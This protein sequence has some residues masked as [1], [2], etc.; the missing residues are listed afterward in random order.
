MLR[1]DPLE[2]GS[3]GAAHHGRQHR[4]AV[5][6]AL[7]PTHHDLAAVEVDVL[8]AQLQALEQA[9]AGAVEERRHQPSRAGEPR[10]HGRHL[11]AAEH[12]GDV[13]R[14]PRANQTVEPRQLHAEHVPVEEQQRTE[15][16]VLGRRAH[17]AILGQVREEAGHLL[18]SERR[19]V[20]LVVKQNVPPDPEDV[21][22]LGAAAHVPQSHRGP[23]PVE[24]AGGPRAV[25]GRRLG[26]RRRRLF[27]TTV[28]RHAHARR[29][30]RPA[31][32]ACPRLRHLRRRIPPGRGPPRQSPAG[33][34]LRA[35]RGMR[36]RPNMGKFLLMLQ[37][38][39]AA[40][41][42]ADPS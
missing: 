40:R 36:S 7:P 14:A 32:R 19:R 15:R 38:T 25:R 6:P 31:L 42:E 16:L 1:P 12:D 23:H 9:E 17:P 21:G 18:G 13:R 24:E 8:H 3:Q 30:A 29:Q 5:S 4:P 22:L 26:D 37:E 34:L 11:L 35:G 28:G 2:V 27:A 10:Q 33:M 41:I 39:D 20:T